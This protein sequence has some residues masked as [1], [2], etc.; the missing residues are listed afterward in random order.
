M[1]VP[2]LSIS[3]GN[4]KT[5]LLGQLAAQALTP[6]PPTFQPGRP[7]VG[8]SASL[9]QS[10]VMQAFARVVPSGMVEGVVLGTLLGKRMLPPRWRPRE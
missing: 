6:G 1:K 5:W 3:H 4:G 2:A 7:I 9:K 8:V 10:R